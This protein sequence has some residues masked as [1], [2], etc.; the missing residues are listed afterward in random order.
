MRRV[1]CTIATGPHVDLLALSA[2]TF[3]A[4][5]RRHG[6]DLLLVRRDP[7]PERPPS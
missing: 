2:L 1:L 6:Y 4:Y 7:S 5:A 3:E